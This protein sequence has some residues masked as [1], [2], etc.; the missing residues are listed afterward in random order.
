MG[1]QFSHTPYHLNTDSVL[2][3]AKFA[4]GNGGTDISKNLSALAGARI[5]DLFQL[6]IQQANQ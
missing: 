3:I 6:T 2:I 5:S 1:G 4:K